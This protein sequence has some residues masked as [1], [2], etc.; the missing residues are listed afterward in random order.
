[1]AIFGI[2]ISKY[3]SGMNLKIA[4]E[5][6]VNFAIIRGGYTGSAAKQCVKDELFEQF[7]SSAKINNLG[8]GVY[9]F[10]RAT[11]MDEGRQ[12]AE[13]LYNNCLKGK[14]FDYPIYID[15]EDSVY[16]SKAGKDKVTKAIKGFCETLEK[17]GYYVGI[18]ANINWFNNYIDT[19][20]L[21]KYDK[22]IAYWGMTR[23]NYPNGGM[24]QFGGE[25]NSLR[26]NKIDNMVCDQDYSYL[27]Y[28][29]IIK[30]KKLNGYGNNSSNNDNSYIIYTVQKG[31]TLS[32]IAKKYGTSYQKIASDNGIINDNLIYSGQ[33]L[34]IYT[35]STPSNQI[36]Y[37]VKKGDT[38]S[39][40]AKKYGTSYQKIASNNGITNPNLIY[41]GQQLIINK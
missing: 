3:Q 25:T 21:K 12:E 30:K 7:Y 38:L 13:F 28:P 32:D 9:Y 24:W 40:I 14:Q 20:K 19:N 5:Q 34:K 33:Q 6:G 22:W 10:S 2:D 29:S 11:S 4:K 39:S 35:N 36:I 37:T 27:D 26:S 15:V 23:P 41:P 8:V 18:Y 1:M 31:D 17:K 16:Q